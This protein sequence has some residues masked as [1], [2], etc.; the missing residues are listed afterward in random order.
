MQVFG[1]KGVKNGYKVKK[2][3]LLA[4]D[5]LLALFGRGGGLQPFWSHITLKSLPTTPSEKIPPASL[6]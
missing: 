2:D 5:I 6:L 4:Q 3:I 1:F